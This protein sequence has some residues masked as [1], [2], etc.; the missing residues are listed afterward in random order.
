MFQHLSV[1]NVDATSSLQLSVSIQ[2]D[3]LVIRGESTVISTANIQ[4]LAK[5]LDDVRM[6]VI[7]GRDI[8]VYTPCL[9]IHIY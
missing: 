3:A 7:Q 4:I 2:S 5:S 9:Y 1:S 6:A 8:T